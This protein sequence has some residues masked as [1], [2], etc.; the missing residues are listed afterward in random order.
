ME[1]KY[2][3]SLAGLKEKSYKTQKE[4][5]AGKREP[6]IPSKQNSALYAA[7]VLK[8]F[9]IGFIVAKNVIGNQKRKQTRKIIKYIITIPN[10][11]RII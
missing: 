5:N 6:L 10:G 2:V 4:T 1:N 11:G 8:R 7:K 9:P 3:A